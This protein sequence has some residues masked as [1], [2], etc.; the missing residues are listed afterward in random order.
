MLQRQPE[1]LTSIFWDA[2]WSRCARFS[3]VFIRIHQ[4][5]IGRLWNRHSSGS[6][7]SS[8]QNWGYWVDVSRV[9]DQGVAAFPEDADP[10]GGP[11]HSTIAHG[12]ATSPFGDG[13]LGTP[14]GYTGR[15][16]MPNSINHVA[17]LDNGIPCPVSVGQVFFI[18]MR[19]NSPNAHVYP[20]S[21]TRMADCRF[22]R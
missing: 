6:V 4:S 15:L 12:T 20:D 14:R 2:L 7:R 5:I 19:V 8:L 16:I 3:Y 22:S 10:P 11:F 17:M 1:Q 13:P 18:N 21:R 9:Q